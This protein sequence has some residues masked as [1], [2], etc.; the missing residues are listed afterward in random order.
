MQ[1]YSI[2]NYLKDVRKVID[3]HTHENPDEIILVGHS[4][5]GYISIIAGERYA[6][7][8][9][10]VSLCPPSGFD[11]PPV[12]WKGKEYRVCQRDLPND[13]TTFREFKVPIAFAY[14]SFTYNAIEAVKRIEKPLMILIA[15]ADTVVPPQDTEKLVMAARNPYSI[16]LEGVGHNFRYSKEDCAIVM[17]EIEKF[18]SKV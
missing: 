13:P 11:N 9:K 17:D 10:I 6:E 5:G 14:D 1:Q 16:R 7:I 2:T 8:T 4:V 12:K 18:L 15:L 3:E